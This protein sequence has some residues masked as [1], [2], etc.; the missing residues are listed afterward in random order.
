MRYFHLVLARV[1]TKYEGLREFFG[2]N[3]INYTDMVRKASTQHNGLRYVAGVKININIR[4]FVLLKA[5]IIK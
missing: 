5:S 1:L 3:G 4:M 2:V